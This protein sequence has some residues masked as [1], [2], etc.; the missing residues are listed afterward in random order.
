MTDTIDL[1]EV[2]E[3]FHKIVEMEL[4]LVSM[5]SRPSDQDDTIP[6]RMKLLEAM[7]KTSALGVNSRQFTDYWVN[8]FKTDNDVHQVWSSVAANFSLYLLSKGIDLSSMTEFVKSSISH[9]TGTVGMFAK[10]NTGETP[11]ELYARITDKT[12]WSDRDFWL[13]CLAFFRMTIS[14]SPLM[15]TLIAVGQAQAG[16]KKPS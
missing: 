14:E 11:I 13:V 12:A 7:A 10:Q 15:I 6:I 3:K 1:K 9:I 16:S 5:L 4:A 8:E 2:T